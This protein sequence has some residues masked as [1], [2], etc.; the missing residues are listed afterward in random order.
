MLL[1][2]TYEVNASGRMQVGGCDLADLAREFGTPLYVYDET[3]LRA[4]L[5]EYRET[6]KRAYP[7]ESLVLYAGKAFLSI[8]MAKL[9]ADEGAGLDL[10]SGGELFLAERAGFPME[11]VFFPGN[12]KTEE[13]VA[14][15]ARLEIGALVVDSLHEIELLRHLPATPH[16]R[17][18][19][20]VSPGI[21]PDT[22]SFIST[23]QLDSKFGF[24]VETGQALDTLHKLLQ[25]PVADVTGVHAHIGSQ[26][27]DLSSFPAAVERILDFLVVARDE[28]GFRARELSMGGG[29][30]IAYT[31]E[32]EPPTPADFVHVVADAV[33]EGCSE[34]GLDLPR[35]LIEPGRSIAGPAGVAVYTVGAIKEIPGVRTYASVDGGMG[36][37][38]RPKLYGARYEAFKVDAP[39]A[40]ATETVTIA[41][42]YCES[43]DIL[44]KDAKMPP[45]TSGDLVAMPA[46]GAYSLA[47]SSNYN[48]NVRP[49]VV[50][51]R[52]GNATLM[53]RRETYEDLLAT[54]VG[55]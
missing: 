30:G 54:E 29:L 28:L 41:G 5:S 31:S 1:P 52:N 47:M 21:Q 17:T 19:L 9:V 12:N 20:R 46:A 23:G 11:R 45:L 22:H 7:G 25:V 16:I 48:Y 50:M 44:I 26:I 38:I 55:L 51:V 32:D 13:E 2:D 35:L 18:T 36:D 39:N 14:A 3:T 37:N 43:T 15:A 24:P 8:A 6:L 34:R 40:A 27:F 4:R 10:V 33:N 49:A 53:R 42:R